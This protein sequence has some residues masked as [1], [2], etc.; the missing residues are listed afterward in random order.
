MVLGTKATMWQA[1]K[2]ARELSH[3][4]M[5]AVIKASSSSMRSMVTA[6]TF[7]LMVE[8]TRV[9]GRSRVCMAMERFPGLTVGCEF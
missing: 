6:L 7:G 8:D 9:S 1:R 5:E 3:G 4:M 2:R